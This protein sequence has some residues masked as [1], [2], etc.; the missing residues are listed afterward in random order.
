MRES[1]RERERERERLEK[2]NMRGSGEASNLLHISSPAVS[3]PKVCGFVRLTILM[4][5]FTAQQE[6]TLNCTHDSW[7]LP[8]VAVINF[9]FV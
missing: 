4:H 7:N 2:F 1:E 9:Y 3:F 8:I 5:H 6:L